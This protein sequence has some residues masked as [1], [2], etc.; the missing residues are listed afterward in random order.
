MTVDVEILVDAS[1]DAL[2]VPTEAVFVADG[3]HFVYRVDG[4]RARRTP[5]ALGRSSI[6]STEVL[7][8]LQEGQVVVVGA[9]GG[10]EDGARVEPRATDVA[11]E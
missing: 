11:A 9:A 10:L 8:G 3:R 6:E 7:E 2:Q 5:V 4:G 1:A